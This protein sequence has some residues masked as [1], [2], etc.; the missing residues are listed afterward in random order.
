MKQETKKLIVDFIGMACL[1]G[2]LGVTGCFVMY[3][4]LSQ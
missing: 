2:M 3:W 4:G 1:F